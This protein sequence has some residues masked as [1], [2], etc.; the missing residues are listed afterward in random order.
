MIL[1]G[2]SVFGGQTGMVHP[3]LAGAG[4]E[5]AERGDLGTVQL[6]SFV[7]GRATLR[8][9]GGALGVALPATGETRG[10]GERGRPVDRALPPLVAAGMPAGLRSALGRAHQRSG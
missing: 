4:W 10:L 9:L 5:F 7:E 8:E 2:A 3:V 6:V 1:E